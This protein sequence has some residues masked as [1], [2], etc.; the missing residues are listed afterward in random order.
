MGFGY[1]FCRY[2]FCTCSISFVKAMPMTQLM[3]RH[4]PNSAFK[5]QSQIPSSIP[6]PVQSHSH[7]ERIAMMS[8]KTHVVPGAVVRSETPSPAAIRLRRC[9]KRREALKTSWLFRCGTT[10]DIQNRNIISLD[11]EDLS[12]WLPGAMPFRDLPAHEPLISSVS[13]QEMW[14]FCRV[15]WTAGTR[16]D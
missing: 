13:S 8:I 11:E 6:A 3:T 4:N 1:L 14:L 12:E 15:L 5:I 9:N 2:S 7:H 16:D 10:Q